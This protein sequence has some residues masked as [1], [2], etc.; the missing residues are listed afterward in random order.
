M[1]NILKEK[2][3]VI[4]LIVILICLILLVVLIKS[5]GILKLQQILGINRQKELSQG[6]N[7][8]IYKYIDGT[9]KMLIT[10][11]DDESGIARI[12]LNNE[13][14]ILPG[15]HV[16]SVDYDFNYND[17]FTFEMTTKDG[18][19][20]TDN[21]TIDDE[22][23]YNSS[24]KMTNILSDEQNYKIINLDFALLENVDYKIEFKT[25]GGKWISCIDSFSVFDYD[26]KDMADENDEVNVY[27]RATNTKDSNQVVQVSKKFKVKMEGVTDSVQA[28]S[29]LSAVKDDGFKTGQYTLEANGETY[30]VHSYEQTGDQVWSTNMIFGT[31][32]DVGTKTS[33]A[34]N[35]VIVKVNGDLTITEGSYVGPYNTEYGGPK[36]LVIYVTGKLTNNGI[37]DNSHGAY[38][39]GQ[40]VYLWKNSDGT[41]E[42]VPA[43]GATTGTSLSN[44]AHAGTG[45]QTGGGGLGIHHW[46]GISGYG[47][48]GTSYSGG[49]GGGDGYNSVG[50]P[51]TN[52]KP[53]GGKGGMGTRTDYQ[54]ELETQEGQDAGR[55]ELR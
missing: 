39:E 5:N 15:K 50:T 34:Q 42:T 29:I 7:Y 45:R 27:V 55:M 36:G 6:I 38:A 51:S 13:R 3:K 44:P 25:E 21:V 32:N 12:N 52:A 23:I 48:T 10:F 8:Q 18:R 53:N 49:S 46:N 22:F 24:I 35:M 54:Q 41:Y 11:K 9:G 40:D 2:K 17:S 16:A 19:T 47:S 43:E 1:K 37:I 20:I 30:T 31:D 26:V 28:D 14:E 4:S 33:Y